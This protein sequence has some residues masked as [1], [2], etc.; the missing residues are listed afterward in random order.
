[1]VERPPPISFVRPGARSSFVQTQRRT[2]FRPSE[3]SVPSVKPA[4]AG[5]GSLRR[6]RPCR[7]YQPATCRKT[8]EGRLPFSV[9][10][11]NA[12]AFLRREPFVVAP[13]GFRS[14]THK[15]PEVS[16]QTGRFHRDDET[17][18][19]SP[20]QRDF[21][22]SIEITDGS[23]RRKAPQIIV[24]W[25]GCSR[26]RGNLFAAANLRLS[27]LPGRLPAT[28]RGSLTK[29]SFVPQSCVQCFLSG[30]ALRAHLTTPH[31]EAQPLD[32]GFRG[33]RDRTKPDNKHWTDY[34]GRRCKG[35]FAAAKR[36]HVHGCS[37]D[38][39]G[40]AAG[41]SEL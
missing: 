17:D 31:P 12:R 23:R 28:K 40:G 21:S 38:S 2:I 22:A 33:A 41:A 11:M 37:H 20:S 6:R 34:A 29:M 10:P 9:I 18:E 5:V 14:R 4:A 32:E 1:V 8:D 24:I 3:P 39:G 15:R 27:V 13:N 26:R 36:A 7:L 30:Y 35:R 19:G 25:T 16:R